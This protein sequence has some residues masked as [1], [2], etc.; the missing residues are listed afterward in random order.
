MSLLAASP[1]LVQAV[2]PIHIKSNRFIRPSS[3]DNLASENEVFFIKGVD[4]QPGGSSAYD[5]TS[6]EDS[7]SDPKICARNA[8]IFQQLGINTLRIYS[9][10][11]DTNHDK[12][13]TILNNAGIYV[14]LDVNSG[15]WG[16]N[17]N[18]ADPS[19]TYNSIYLKRVFKF[20][21]AFKN[22]PNVLGFF[23]GNEVINDEKNYADIDPQYI[24]AVQRDMKQYIAKHSN[25]TIPIGYS[26]ADNSN[27]RVATH[28][29]LQC[30]ALNGTAINTELEESKADFYGLNTYSWC[31]G[32][33]S[34]STSGYDILNSTF[35]DTIIPLFFSEFGCN[36]NLPRTFDAVSKGLYDGLIDV[37]SGGLVYEFTE[38]ANNYGL[39]NIDSDDNVQY[40]DD[41]ENL[42]RQ[43]K[44]VDLPNIKEYDVHN[45]TVFKCNAAEITSFYKSFGVENFTLPAQPSNIASMIK[46]GV[47]GNN[48]G[49]LISDYTILDIDYTI[50]DSDGNVQSASITIDSTN[51]MNYLKEVSTSTSS[52]THASFSSSSSSTKSSSSKGDAVGTFN[53]VSISGFFILLSGLLTAFL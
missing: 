11:P 23:S 39:V 52:S 6:G 10:N 49:S 30:N 8:Y 45:N 29:Y 12:C 9:L 38:E 20:I 31:S 14:I 41:F 48:T 21:E 26:A 19:G 40:K 46:N 50:K 4:Y 33:G 32:T 16:E 2:L 5:A 3:P 53:S 28:Q 34:W 36:T 43:Y 7:L 18:R 13:M 42:Q 24:R 35:S 17:L 44:A 51:L 25:R 37:F 27:L 47:D 1:A 22:Y 15:S